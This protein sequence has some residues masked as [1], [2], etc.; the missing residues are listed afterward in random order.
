[1][2]ES[3]EDDFVWI[4]GLVYNKNTL[5]IEQVKGYVRYPTEEGEW[6]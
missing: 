3:R 5:E 2:P 1:M 6:L 4:Y